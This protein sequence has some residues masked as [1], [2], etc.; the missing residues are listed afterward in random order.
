MRE[1]EY[2]GGQ[3][4]DESLSQLALTYATLN[5]A[6]FQ[7]VNLL[8]PRMPLA[9]HSQD[10]RRAGGWQR[11]QRVDKEPVNAAS[12]DAPYLSLQQVN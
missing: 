7:M 9:P 8:N 6:P 1:W 10:A 2:L 12:C 3:K 11:V 5:N 4:C